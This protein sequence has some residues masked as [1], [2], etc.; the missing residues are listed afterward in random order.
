LVEV[1]DTLRPG[2]RDNVI[3]NSLQGN[4]G[5]FIIGPF[6]SVSPSTS[7]GDTASSGIETG[8][9]FPQLKNQFIQ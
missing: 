2:I 7:I 3:N 1:P 5:I 8:L 9:K 4:Q 6:A